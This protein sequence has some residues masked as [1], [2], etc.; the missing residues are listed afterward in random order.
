V[1][2]EARAEGDAVSTT[3]AV[4]FVLLCWVVIGMGK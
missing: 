3:L 2:P 1:L 4:V